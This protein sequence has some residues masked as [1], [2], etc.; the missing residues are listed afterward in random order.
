MF[1]DSRQYYRLAYVQPPVAPGD[2]RKARAIEVRVARPD[3]TVRSRRQY[4]PKPQP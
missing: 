4:L 3:T 2:D 1:R